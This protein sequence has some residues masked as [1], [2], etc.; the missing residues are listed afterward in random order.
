MDKNIIVGFTDQ[1]SDEDL[2]GISVYIDGLAQFVEKCQTPI[3]ISI[4][5]SWGTGK[6]SVM[7]I[8]KRKLDSKHLV[9]TLFSCNEY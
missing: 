4:Q 8:V 1:A 3:T 7:R 9:P 5:G 2:F 6:T